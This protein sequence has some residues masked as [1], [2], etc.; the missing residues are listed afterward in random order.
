MRI[1]MNQLKNSSW[2]P[3]VIVALIGLFGTCMTVLGGLAGVAMSIL[4]KS[5]GWY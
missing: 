1:D 5:H 2:S 3:S 4:A